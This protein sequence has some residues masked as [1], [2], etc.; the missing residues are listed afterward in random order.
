MGNIL[1][2]ENCKEKNFFSNRIYSGRHA[3][4]IRVSLKPLVSLVQQCIN[5][6]F[7]FTFIK[8]P[9][10]AVRLLPLSITTL[11][12]ITADTMNQ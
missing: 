8:R 1:T 3:V 7:S 11:S 9:D 12:F 2:K 4:L 5:V 6:P 10:I